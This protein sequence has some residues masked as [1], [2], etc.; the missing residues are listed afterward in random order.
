VVP[1]ERWAPWGVPTVVLGDQKAPCRLSRARTCPVPGHPCL[2][3]IEAAD[4]VAAVQ[5]LVDARTAAGLES[6]AL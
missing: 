2:D 1:A 4:V 6:V 3:M 5:R